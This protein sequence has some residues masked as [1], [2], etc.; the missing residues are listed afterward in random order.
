VPRTRTSPT[1]SSARSSLKSSLR[2]ISTCLQSM[3]VREIRLKQNRP[4]ASHQRVERDG[5]D[6][7]LLGFGSLRF[8]LHQ[9]AREHQWRHTASHKSVRMTAVRGKST[10]KDWTRSVRTCPSP[11]LFTEIKERKTWDVSS[12]E[13]LNIIRDFTNYALDHWGSDAMGVENCRL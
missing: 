9:P 7:L 1:I 3:A 10:T 8:Q 6:T 12:Q 5:G 11:W 4:T 13:R 2:S